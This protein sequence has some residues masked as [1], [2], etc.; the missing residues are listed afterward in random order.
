M[1]DLRWYNLSPKLVNYPVFAGNFFS[2]T[3]KHGLNVGAKV[4]VALPLA[5]HLRNTGPQTTNFPVT[6]LVKGD[7]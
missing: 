7:V 4:H 6:D 1:V 3:E 5:E 2:R